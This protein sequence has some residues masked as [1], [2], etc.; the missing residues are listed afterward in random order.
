M[1]VISPPIVVCAFY[2]F[3]DLPDFESLKQPLLRH[4]LQNDIKGTILLAHEGINGTV[5]GTREAIDSLYA[6]FD[7]DPRF[8]GIT[9]KEA[10]HTEQAFKRTKVRLKKEIVTI[11]DKSVDPNAVVGTYVKPKDWNTLISDPDVI[12]IDARNTYEVEAG[13][14]KNAIDP[15]TD[16]FRDLPAWMDEKL[17]PEKN[18]KVA[19]FCT[20]GI[21]CEKSTSYLK[22]RGFDEVYHLEGGILKYLEEIPQEESMWEGECFVFDERITVDHDLKKG[23]YAECRACGKVTLTAEEQADPR[24][25]PG[26]SCPECYGTK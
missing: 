14:F 11:G 3:V 19:M 12:L 20:G 13:T 17:D 21:R 4:L 16:A 15:E 10:L 5:S 1:S 8:A 6:W 7:A 9:T 24:Y 22:A 26:V 2:R 18:K 23:S 25:V